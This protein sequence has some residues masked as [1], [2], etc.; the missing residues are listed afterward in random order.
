M[1]AGDPMIARDRTLKASPL[2]MKPLTVLVR[3]RWGRSTRCTFDGA[4]DAPRALERC[5]ASRGMVYDQRGSLLTAEAL[6]AQ[7]R[8]GSSSLPDVPVVTVDHP[9][10]W[11]LT[12]SAGCALLAMAWTVVRMLSKPAWQAVRAVAI[13]DACNTSACDPARSCAVALASGLETD[14]GL[15]GSRDN[16]TPLALAGSIDC[17]K[18]LDGVV[19]QRAWKLL[20][21]IG[22]LCTVLTVVPSD[23]W[24]AIAVVAW[25]ITGT[26]P[27]FPM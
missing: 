19:W 17:V 14:F 24:C 25:L 9:E 21:A 4:S 23:R 6:V 1:W 12:C 5:G 26:R 16:V 22:T 7:L 2:S 20:P 8:D 3:G 18:L 27:L 13:P 10:T 11:W 15:Y